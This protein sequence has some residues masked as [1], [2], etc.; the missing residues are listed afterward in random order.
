MTIEEIEPETFAT[1]SSWLYTNTIEPLE[2]ADDVKEREKPGKECTHLAKLWI[3]ARRCMMRTL[4]NQV[5]DVMHNTITGRA[6]LVT[7]FYP[8]YDL[9]YKEAAVELQ[10]MS[11]HQFVRR[12]ARAAFNNHVVNLPA[13]MVIDVAK[14][15]KDSLT[16]GEDH[17]DLSAKG[18]YHVSVK[19][20]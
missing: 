20:T 11:Y 19:N 16:D 10:R 8:C 2:H 3:L 14:H 17:K 12:L 1:F 6:F 5:S 4:Q 9:V 18:T 7:D 15:L 13:E